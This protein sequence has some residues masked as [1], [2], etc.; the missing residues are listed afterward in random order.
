MGFTLGGAALEIAFLAIALFACILIS[1]ALGRRIGV[2]VLQQDIEAA[3]R[4]IGAVE[5]AVFALLGLLLAFT[6]SGAAA[7]FEERRHLITEE[8]NAIG[9]AY[10]RIDVMPTD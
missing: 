10:L 4:G 3:P 1:M 7:R 6:F 2:I 9:T 8:S 5:G